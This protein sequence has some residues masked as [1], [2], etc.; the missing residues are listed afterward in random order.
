VPEQPRLDVR[1]PQR[2]AQQRIFLQVDLAHRQVVRRPPVR[3]G[4]IRGEHAKALRRLDAALEQHGL[5]TPESSGA[6]GAV[7][8]AVHSLTALVNDELPL[9]VLQRGEDVGLTAYER[10]I[11][12]EGF[13]P[14]FVQQLREGH[15]L[16]Q[17]HRE[18]LQLLRDAITT[19]PNRPMI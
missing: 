4:E 3:V 2:L 7:A 11:A 9:Q 15:A 8:N 17:R 16:C 1:R 5:K 14:A 19:Q 6:W 10:A 13:E 12:A 18:R